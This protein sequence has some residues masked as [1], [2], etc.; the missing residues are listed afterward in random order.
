MAMSLG[1]A[2]KPLTHIREMGLLKLFLLD[3][4]APTSLFLRDT[5]IPDF[6]SAVADSPDESLTRV[7]RRCRANPVRMPLQPGIP[8][9]MARL[10]GKSAGSFPVARN[11][12]NKK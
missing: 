6:F 3:D 10:R 4:L 11:L 1:Y 7:S 12:L 8:P 9:A 5:T 2:I